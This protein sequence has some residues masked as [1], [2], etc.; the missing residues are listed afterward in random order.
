MRILLCAPM[1]VKK[2]LVESF[3]QNGHVICYESKKLKKHEINYATHYLELRAI[4]HDLK[5]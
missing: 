5:M 4:V 2:G 1:H 3:T